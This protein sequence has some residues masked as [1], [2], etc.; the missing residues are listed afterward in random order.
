MQS[1][2]SKLTVGPAQ[3]LAEYVNARKAK[4]EKCELPNRYWNLPEWKTEYIRQVTQANALLKSFSIEAIVSALNSKE[5][6]WTYSL[7]TKGLI[8]VIQREQAKIDRQNVKI[9]SLGIPSKIEFNKTDVSTEPTHINISKPI[10][11]QTKF[12][13]LEE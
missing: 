9:E 3:Y 1:K 2:S 5:F 12:S 13:G 4:K 6:N 8:D 11:K 7:M 10:P